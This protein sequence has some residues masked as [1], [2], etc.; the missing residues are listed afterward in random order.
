[1][2]FMPGRQPA[3]KGTAM[4][5]ASHEMRDE[6]DFSGAVRG[7]YAARYAEGVIL[8]NWMAMCPGFSGMKRRLTTH[9]AH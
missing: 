9:C 6:Y 5:K 2:Q 7:K 4:K 3:K 1:M 8:L